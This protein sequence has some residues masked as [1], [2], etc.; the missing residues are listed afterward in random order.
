MHHSWHEHADL[1]DAAIRALGIDAPIY[2]V[3]F[4]DGFTTA[5]IRT[6]DQVYTYTRNAD[7]ASVIDPPAPPARA[8]ARA[9]SAARRVTAGKETNK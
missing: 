7:A 8:R 4:R 9:S 3:E 6:G 1:V 2:S 5:I